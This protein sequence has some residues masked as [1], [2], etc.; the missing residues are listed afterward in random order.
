[1]NKKLE[2][3]TKSGNLFIFNSET[4]RIKFKNESTISIGYGGEVLS[5]TK[6]DYEET[7]E[8]IQILEVMKGLFE[9]ES[10]GVGS[11]ETYKTNL[12]SIIDSFIQKS[13]ENNLFEQVEAFKTIRTFVSQ[14]IINERDE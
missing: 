1:M 11:L 2:I 9:E 13:E 7:I 5:H 3:K 12:L 6:L 14:D 8:W 4:D 10:R